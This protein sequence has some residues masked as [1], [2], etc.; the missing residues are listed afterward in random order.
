MEPSC[1]DDD[2]EDEKVTK[3]R[4]DYDETIDDHDDVVPGSWLILVRVN[5]QK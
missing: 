5:Q 3:E 4:Y 2:A 1:L